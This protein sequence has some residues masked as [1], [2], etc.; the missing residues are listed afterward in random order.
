MLPGD[1]ALVPA[2]LPGPAF[3][4]RLAGGAV[5]LDTA[6]FDAHGLH[7]RARIKSARGPLWLSVPVDARRFG[8]TLAEVRIDP[9]RSWRAR[10]LAA[11][12]TSYRDAPFFDWTY[13]VLE[14][15]LARPWMHLA[16]LNIAAI[17]GLCGL[18]EIPIEL[19][20]A[21][22]LASP[23]PESPVDY[24]FPFYAQLHGPFLPHVSVVDLLFNAGPRARAILAKGAA[25][26]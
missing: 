2:Y 11:I 24:E 26:A 1:L 13:P 20:L 25:A 6:P 17:E 21:S 15:L 9:A 22:D 16:D 5:L 12:M 8:E 7:P 18:L 14:S 10:H 19:R 4:A 3:F 23:P